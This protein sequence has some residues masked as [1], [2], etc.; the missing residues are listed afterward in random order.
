MKG[1]RVFIFVL[2]ML[3]T[4]CATC[5]ILFPQFRKVVDTTSKKTST[6]YFWYRESS[7]PVAETQSVA[8]NRTYSHRLLCPRGQ[9]YH[10]AAAAL[11]VAATALIGSSML[12]AAC[13]IDARYN[14]GLAVASAFMAFL[15]FV[16]F[17]AVVSWTVYTYLTTLCPGETGQILGAKD[18]GYTLAEGFYLLC[19]ATGGSLLCFIISFVLCCSAVC[20]TIEDKGDE[21]YN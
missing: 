18:D 4:A 2:L 3:F 6:V 11:S 21:H 8:I 9:L 16:C 14:N 10:T 5:S 15:S 13:W 7:M 17:S 1:C 12:F 20:C 19:A